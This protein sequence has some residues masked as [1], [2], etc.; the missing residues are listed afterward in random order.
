[1]LSLSSVDVS[2]NE[3]SGPVPD[4]K[5]FKDA[6]VDALKN[7]KG[8]CGNGFRG[9]KP[10]N[11]NPTI[12]TE[13]DAKEHA[14]ERILFYGVIALGFGVGFWGLFLVLL[15]KKEKWWFPYWRIINSIVIRIIGCTQ[16]N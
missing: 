6:P 9:L 16:K 4:I 11:T 3:L 12:E 15:L 5:A 10:C 13:E 1:M 14:N 7:N 2:H 8:L